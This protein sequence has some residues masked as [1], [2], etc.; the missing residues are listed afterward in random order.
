MNAQ[1]T[2]PLFREKRPRARPKSQSLEDYG[3]VREWTRPLTPRERQTYLTPR[4]DGTTYPTFY[5]MNTRP[6]GWLSRHYEHGESVMHIRLF[7]R[8][9]AR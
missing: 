6:W 2:L 8:Y 4:L 5:Q 3:T 7:R 9:E 1:P